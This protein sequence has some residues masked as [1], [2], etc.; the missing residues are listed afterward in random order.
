MDNIYENGVAGSGGGGVGEDA[1]WHRPHYSP[2]Q[3]N[4]L[5]DHPHYLPYPHPGANV[6][7]P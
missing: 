6:Y 2:T 3:V 5:L 4:V 7:M 1:I